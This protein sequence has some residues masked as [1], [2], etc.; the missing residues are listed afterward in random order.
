MPVSSPSA[1]PRYRNPWK[2]VHWVD[3]LSEEQH[4]QP[5][6]P[7][8]T[9]VLHLDRLRAT[10]QTLSDSRSRE[11]SWASVAMSNDTLNVYVACIVGAP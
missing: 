1:G 9:R 4:R 8:N 10:E 5:M 11:E 6:S 2:C 3:N 7:S